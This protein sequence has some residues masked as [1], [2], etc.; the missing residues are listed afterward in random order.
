MFLPVGSWI[1]VGLIA[2]KQDLESAE[3]IGS[4]GDARPPQIIEISIYRERRVRVVPQIVSRCLDDGRGIETLDV[5]NEIVWVRGVN[6]VQLQCVSREVADVESDNHAC[7]RCDCSS[8]HVLVISIGQRQTGDRFVARDEAVGHRTIHC[9]A[10]RLELVRRQVTPLLDNCTHPLPMHVLAPARTK[11]PGLG[12]R[13]NDAAQARRRRRWRQR[14]PRWWR[15]PS[16]PPVACA[17]SRGSTAALPPPSPRL[18]PCE[19]VGTCARSRVAR[20]IVR[21][22]AARPSGGRSPLCREER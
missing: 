4:L 21:D 18:Q 10:R 6:A 16:V 13:D 22:G 14:K 9:A 11:E 17:A 15:S 12:E 5:E 3:M 2:F 19:P 20:R 7:P 1:G 8:E